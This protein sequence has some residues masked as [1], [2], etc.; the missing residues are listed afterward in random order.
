MSFLYSILDTGKSALLSQQYGISVTGHNIANVNTPGYTRQR[1]QL[2]TNFPIST[3][4]GQIGTGV[5]VA[6]VERV[7]DRFVGAQIQN[8]TMN[9]GEWEAYRDSLERLEA[10]FN[11][12][13][14]YGLNNVMGEFW[15]AWQDLSNNPGGQ[16]ERVALIAKS[17]TMSTTFNQFRKDITTIQQ[18][19]DFNIRMTVGEINDLSLKISDLNKRISEAE[20]IGQNANDYRDRRDLLLN[21]MSLLIDINSF[22]TDDGKVTVLTGSGRPLVENLSAWNLSTEPDGTGLHDI[23]WVDNDGNS[24]DIT[25]EV[26]GGKLKGWVEVRDVVV[27]K[28]RDD[29]DTLAKGIIDEVNTLH[30]AGYGLVNAAT[31][32]PYTGI[33]FFTGTS[34]ADIAV[35]ATVTSDFRAVAASATQAGIP[36]DNDNAVNIANLQLKL[37]MNGAPAT[38]TFDEF[39]GAMISDLGTDVAGAKD[40]YSHQ[41]DMVVLLENYRETISGVSLDEEMIELVKYQH[42]Y[43]SAARLITIVDEMMQ[44]ILNML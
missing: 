28:Y 18:D 24:V 8:E 41:K 6:E 22:E 1:V 7:Y 20:A 32:L 23:V 34:A 33:D 5:G 29:L 10:V 3:S 17:E 39:F 27:P 30:S 38:S 13:E 43:E 4:P 12:S 2:E 44:T 25:A 42:G 36:G 21:E 15:N 37:T 26:S 16:A 31:G 35:S 40:S 19:A 14:G 9:L 11:E